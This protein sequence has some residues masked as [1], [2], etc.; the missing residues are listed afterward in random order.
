MLIY[1]E[2][3]RG[4]SDSIINYNRCLIYFVNNLQQISRA[5]SKSF[6]GG[7]TFTKG[8]TSHRSPGVETDRN[9]CV[10]ITP[11]SYFQNSSRFAIIIN[12]LIL[13]RWLKYFFNDP[14][15]SGRF[16]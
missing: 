11:R 7:E 4:I 10:K 8:F 12:L 14:H 13:E 1:F 3:Y 9:K 15:S 5:A 2:Y 16:L 6:S